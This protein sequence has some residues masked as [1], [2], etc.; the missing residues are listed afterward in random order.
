MTFVRV[1]DVE[2][3][4]LKP[5]AM[6]CELGW[7]DVSFIESSGDH[8]L[9]SWAI[10]DVQ[11]MLVNPGQPIPPEMSAI[12]GIIDADVVGALSWPEARALIFEGGP[13][14]L[15]AHNARFEQQWF[16]PSQID[17]MA[18]IDTYAVAI[19][20]APQAPSHAQQVLRYWLKLECDTSLA[21]PK[22]RA[23]TDAYVCAILLQRMLAKVTID[24][25]VE[26]TRE[27]ILLPRLTF[28][29]HRGVSFA[30]VP[31]D[32]LQWL[33]KQEDMD[34]D[35][36]RTARAELKIRGADK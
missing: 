23:G 9:G 29:K 31:A 33:V 30:E 22:H 28:G 19:K 11:S 7:C 5:P 4:G 32:Y 35:V 26:I 34:E 13:T 12:H 2:T 3:S 20:W 16:A 36:E 8:K 15:C 18:W 17:D 14:A 27:P 6:P 25:L 1:I 21:E 24:K 10:T